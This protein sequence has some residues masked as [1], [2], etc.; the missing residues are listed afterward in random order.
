MV[1]LDH[2]EVDGLA[3]VVGDPAE[4]LELGVGEHRVVHRDLGPARAQRLDRREHPRERGLLDAPRYEAPSTT[5]RSPFR[6]PSSSAA[7]ATTRSGI[8]AF[9]ARAVA[10]IDASGSP[11]RYRR[12]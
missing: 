4:A 7:R 11:A 6:S 10:T 1:R 5:A 12:G 8:A 2:G 3:Q 9:A